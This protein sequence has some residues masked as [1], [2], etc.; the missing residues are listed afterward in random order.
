MPLEPFE[1]DLSKDPPRT[2]SAGKLDRNFKRC[3]PAERGQLVGPFKIVP[4]DD[5]WYLELRGAPSGL[6]VLGASNGVLKWIPTQNC[7]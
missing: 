6:A 5:G 4:S 3:H 7:P 2:V 1:P